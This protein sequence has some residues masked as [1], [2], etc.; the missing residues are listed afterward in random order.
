[1]SAARDAH[2]LS[3]FQRKERA[4]N[5]AQGNLNSAL[6]IQCRNF[7]ESLASVG[8]SPDDAEQLL[9]KTLMFVAGR[10]DPSIGGK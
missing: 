1:M 10:F 8:V 4:V 7:L 6:N 2:G 9:A 3:P 5:M